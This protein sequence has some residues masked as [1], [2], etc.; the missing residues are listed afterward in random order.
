MAEPFS[1][2]SR[3][4]FQRLTESETSLEY[5]N[6]RVRKHKPDRSVPKPW[7][8]LLLASWLACFVRA[9]VHKIEPHNLADF[10]RTF[11]AAAAAAAAAAEEARL[12]CHQCCR[13]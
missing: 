7:P 3:A 11:L 4:G 10:T 2:S 13:S 12:C 6:R 9:G 8:P 5:W 1:A